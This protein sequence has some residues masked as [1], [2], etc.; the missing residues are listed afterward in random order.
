MIDHGEH[1][2]LLRV[3]V[4]AALLIVRGLPPVID[5]DTW[6]RSGVVLEIS[7]VYLRGLEERERKPETGTG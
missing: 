1:T 6:E 2:A 7:A 4:A 3:K 5:P